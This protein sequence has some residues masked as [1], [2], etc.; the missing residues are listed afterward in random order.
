MMLS[1]N[2]LILGQASER[3]F[4]ENIGETY[5]NDSGVAIKFSKF[6]V[7]NFTEKL[8][9]RGEVKDIFRNTGEMN[10]W[11]VDDKKVEEEN[12]LKEFTKSDII[13]KLGGKEM[14]ARFPLKRYFDVNQE[15]DIEGIHIFIV[16]TSTG[17]NWNVDSSIYKWIKQFTLNRGRDL[18]VKTYGKDFKFLQRDDT[19]DA[20]WNGLTM[21]DGIAARFKNRN[22]SD[23]GLHPIPVL[24]G[25][26]GVG[27]SRFLDEVERLLVQYANESDDDE[28]RDAFTNMT[29]INTTYGNGCPARDM[30]V[31]I[32]AEASLAIRILFEYFKPKH[33]FGDY[34]FSHFQSLCNNYSNISY[35]TLST[36]IRVV[37]ADV[38]IQKNQEIKSNPLLVLVLGIDEL[39]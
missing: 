36:A 35:F 20:L 1:L 25:G 17:P 16:P 23:K 37:Y 11:K 29:V 34:D 7:S 10:L 15:M 39:N 26:P 3:C 21:L 13:E 32:G 8:F 24:A 14:V 27:K 5:K 6:T 31:T 33:D 30:D 19:I 9:H 22:V 28:I 18:L 4:T 12:N 38:I 2:C